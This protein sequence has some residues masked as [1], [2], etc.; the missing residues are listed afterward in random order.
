MTINTNATLGS[1]YT[2]GEKSPVT[3][4]YVCV[5]CEEAGITHT[6]RVI[7]GAAL[8]TCE[9]TDVRWRLESFEPVA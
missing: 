5:T 8:P 4:D 7:E 9:H 6:I 1:T 3:G 2:T